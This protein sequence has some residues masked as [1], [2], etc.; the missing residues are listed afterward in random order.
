MKEK[1]LITLVL[2]VGSQISF[3]TCTDKQLEVKLSGVTSIMDA[4]SLTNSEK[5]AFEKIWVTPEGQT[6]YEFHQ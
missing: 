3:V 1:N 4:F 6:V 5:Y 2:G